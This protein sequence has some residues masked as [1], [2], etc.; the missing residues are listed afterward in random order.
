MQASC[1]LKFLLALIS[2]YIGVGWYNLPVLNEHKLFD[3][4]FKTSVSASTSTDEA[5]APMT[6]LPQP[7]HPIRIG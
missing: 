6:Y 4:S 5:I 2:V 7:V 3:L 1:T